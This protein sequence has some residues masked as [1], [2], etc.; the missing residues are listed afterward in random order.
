MTLKRRME[1]IRSAAIQYMGLVC[2]AKSFPIPRPLVHKEWTLMGSR[3][4]LRYR[5]LAGES[6]ISTIHVVVV[7]DE[8]VQLQVCA[9]QSCTIGM[10]IFS[11]K[12]TDN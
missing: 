4:Y 8:V 10:I 3:S 2:I 11:R 1:R 5:N 12:S 9:K 7:D 6:C